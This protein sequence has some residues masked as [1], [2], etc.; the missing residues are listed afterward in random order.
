MKKLISSLTSLALALMFIMPSLCGC[1]AKKEK[2]VIYTCAEDFRVEDLDAGLK[3][4]FPEYDVVLEYMTTGNAAAKLL[5]EGKNTECDIIYDLEYG[6]LAQL[7]EKGCL[8]DLSGYDMSVYTDDAV[9]S[10]NYIP[11]LRNG[12]AIIINTALLKEKGLDEPKS[13]DDLLK[14]EYK[15]LISMPSP[16]SSGTGYMFLKNLVNAR[17]E[18]KAFEYF[19]ALTPNILQYTSSGSGPVNALISGEAAI[20]LGMTAQAVL[21]INEGA[22]LKIVFFD[23]GSPYSLYGLSIVGGK[24]ERESVRR[25]FDYLYSPYGKITNEKFYPEQIFKDFTPEI[26]NYPQNIVY[27]D[28]SGNTIAEKTRLLDKWKY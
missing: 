26:K 11:E 9:V 6:Y 2:V 23:E 16:K 25:V 17:G 8:A 24:E 10:K 19:D 15:G 22:K 12:G 20:G 3:A 14:P 18:D 1:A 28:M 13:Y 5:S 7:D 27:G 21:K 4:E